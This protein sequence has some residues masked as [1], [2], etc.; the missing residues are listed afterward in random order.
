MR[1]NGWTDEWLST[2]LWWDR[3]ALRG[4]APSRLEEKHVA[5]RLKKQRIV[6]GVLEYKSRAN[7]DKN[8]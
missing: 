8:E 2:C 3:V 7:D 1:L 4:G 5:A 6:M